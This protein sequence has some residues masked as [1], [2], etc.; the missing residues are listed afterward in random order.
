MNTNERSLRNESCSACRTERKNVL[1]LVTA[2]RDVAEHEDLRAARA[3]RAVLELDRHAAGLQRGAHR[4]PH[5]DVGVALAARELV[6]LGGQPALELGDDAVHGG[7]VLDRPGRAAPG[8]ARSAAAWAAGSRCARSARAR[9]R[10][11]AAARSAAA[12]RGGR[13]RG[14]GRPAGRSGWGSVRRPSARRIR[15]TSTPSTPEPSP[16]AEG[17]DR[18]PGQVA[19]RRLGAVLQSAPAICWR[20]VVEVDLEVAAGLGR[21]RPRRSPGAR[22]RPRRRGRRSGRRRASKMR[23]V[24]GRL[25]QRRGQRAAGSRPGSVQRISLQRGERVEQLRGADRHALVAQ[26]LGERQQLPGEAPG[27]AVGD[28]GVELAARAARHGARCQAAAASLGA[29]ELDPDPRGDGVQ[30]GAVLDDH[31]HRLAERVG[32]DVRRRRAAAAP[33]PSRSTRRCSAAS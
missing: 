5:V 20:S 30:V 17:G 21:G 3:L 15:C 11:A 32:V 13:R 26:L 1:A 6:A 23:A 24:L 27:P 33:G 8:R 25:G 12:G 29:L 31:A 18:Q 4:A 2:G 10:A 14:A 22:P 16:L 9:A 7:E 28:P 19:Q